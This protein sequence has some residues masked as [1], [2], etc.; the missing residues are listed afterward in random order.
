MWKSTSKYILW[1]FLSTSPHSKVNEIDMR[2]YYWA[3]LFYS[4]A[5]IF[6]LEHKKH[7]YKKV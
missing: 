2:C 4:Q 3:L 1:L 7:F 6:I 5:V